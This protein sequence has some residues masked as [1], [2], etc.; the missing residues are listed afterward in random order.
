MNT[1]VALAILSFFLPIT[2]S[3]EEVTKETLPKICPK[4]EIRK[5]EAKGGWL[6][7]EIRIPANDVRFERLFQAWFTIKDDK[8]E[9][10]SMSLIRI[11]ESEGVKRLYAYATPEMLKNSK[12]RLDFK[13]KDPTISFLDTMTLV[14]PSLVD[15]K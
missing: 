10:V 5:T 12:I 6:E 8:Q 15:I 9:P 13:S 3:A 2:L 4:L 14:L 1:Q 7:I 11:V